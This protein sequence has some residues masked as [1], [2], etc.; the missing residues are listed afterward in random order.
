MI[1]ATLRGASEHYNPVPMQGNQINQ[2]L[3][4]AI[5][6][7]A[8]RCLTRAAATGYTITLTYPTGTS[9]GPD[10]HPGRHAPP[11]ATP[12][13]PSPPPSTTP[14]TSPPATPAYTTKS[15]PNS[16]A[17]AADRL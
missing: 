3:M 9:M 10:P 17:A 6:N 16:P 1:T 11:P 14:P 5:E 4:K 2:G 13:Y 15:A 8:K 12:P 7:G